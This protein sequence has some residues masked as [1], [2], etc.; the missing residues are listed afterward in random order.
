LDKELRNGEITTR[1]IMRIQVNNLSCVPQLRYRSMVLAVDSA[2]VE[3]RAQEL[4]ASSWDV[5]MALAIE[6]RASSINIG[7]VHVIKV[8]AEGNAWTVSM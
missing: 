5:R 6:L 8:N 4:G 1:L 2:L 3:A 7:E